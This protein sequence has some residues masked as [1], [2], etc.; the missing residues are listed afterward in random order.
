M[1]NITYPIVRQ[2]AD[3][4]LNIIGHAKQNGL[5]LAVTANGDISSRPAEGPSFSLSGIRILFV[6][7]CRF[8]GI[9]KE[10]YEQIADA[11]LRK[12]ETEVE[13][14]RTWV[15]SRLP[16]ASLRAIRKDISR[17]NFERASSTWRQ[18]MNA[19]E[20]TENAPALLEQAKS[21]DK[22]VAETRLEHQVMQ[23]FGVSFDEA[24][25]IVALAGNPTD[26]P[27]LRFLSQ[28][29][30]LEIAWLRLN[31]ELTPQQALL[32]SVLA[33]PLAGQEPVRRDG[34]LMRARSEVF[35]KVDEAIAPVLPA[36]WPD[37]W[38]AMPDG[39]RRLE[40]SQMFSDHFMAFLGDSV[41]DSKFDNDAGLAVKFI[42]DAGRTHFRFG[43][44]REAVTVKC[45][46]RSAVEALAGYV[47]DPAV[48]RSI[49][50]ALF[51]AGGN[52]L[53]YALHSA[54]A[55]SG[56]S[57]FS[58][59]SLDPNNAEQNASANFWISL[60]KTDNGRLRVGYTVYWKH[61]TLMDIETNA[62]FKINSSKSNTPATP[63]D[64][65]TKATAVLEFDIEE[66]R[67]KIINPQL[68]RAPELQM[69]IEPDRDSIVDTIIEQTLGNL[70]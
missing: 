7:F 15:N 40:D 67:Q 63:T 20:R 33:G 17:G 64:H 57:L 23:T 52:G 3:Q 21:G 31:T 10:N 18:V 6:Q 50:A 58:I 62:K 39:S 4:A 53:T 61:F 19:K 11:V 49:S 8:L 48:R 5:S 41:K 2:T 16:D 22:P 38:Q 47:P 12:M 66:L 46:F 32:S 69:T 36:G 37:K 42:E 13:S 51:Q 44:G 43:E 29:Q 56:R 27:Q 54:L 26:D 34:A 65:T 30:R 70:R 14:A 60:Q 1:Q 28:A 45:N 35:A 24:D 9:Y 59:F 55:P 25:A 68:V